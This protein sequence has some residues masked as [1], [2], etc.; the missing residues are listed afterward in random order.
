M[1]DV[2]L[3]IA[4][5]SASDIAQCLSAAYWDG[6][7]EQYHKWRAIL[8]LTRLA[9]TLGFNLAEAQPQQGAA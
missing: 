6:Q 7:R 1:A 3:C 4:A 8:A 2:K 5:Q 9:E